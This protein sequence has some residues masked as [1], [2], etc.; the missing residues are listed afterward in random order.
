LAL[1]LAC[2]TFFPARLV[3]LIKLR[4]YLKN[5]NQLILIPLRK[6]G[7]NTFCHAGRRD[8]CHAN[9]HKQ[10]FLPQ[11]DR[12]LALLREAVKRA[13]KEVIESEHKESDANGEV[14]V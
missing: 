9:L 5:K 12:K 1:S 2:T 10:F 4:K 13:P 3:L 14:K 11:V 6:G 7:D 8:M